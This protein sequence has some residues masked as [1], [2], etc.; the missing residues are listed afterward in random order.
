MNIILFGPPGAGK[1]TQAKFII[2]KY[3]IPQIST[4]EML[5][6][7]VKGQTQLGLIAKQVMDAGD[8]VPDSVVLGLIAERLSCFDCADGFVLDGFPRTIPQ[9]LELVA[10]L[11]KLNKNIDC[12]ISLE[13]NDSEVIE[14]LSGRRTCSACGKGYHVSFDPPEKSGKCDTCGSDLFQRD[15]DSEVTIKN[16]L[17]VY[18][19]MTSPLKDF[20]QKVGLLK[21][22]DGCGAIQDIQHQICLALEGLSGDRS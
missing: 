22:V 2:N 11:N 12:V 14:R 17:A 4:G 13:V 16:R 9:A 7:A 5:R 18:E 3:G 20:Y 19:Q 1:G 10:I 15:D 21:C 8:L 6:A